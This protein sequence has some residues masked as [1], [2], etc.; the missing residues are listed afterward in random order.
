M[1][2]EHKK[3][4]PAVTGTIL[5]IAVVYNRRTVC[6]GLLFLPAASAFRFAFD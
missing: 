1:P 4:V 5:H 3:I 6:S 2:A